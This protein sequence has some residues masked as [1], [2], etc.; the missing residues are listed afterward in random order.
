MRKAILFT[1][2]AAAAGCVINASQAAAP[3]EPTFTLSSASFQDGG[4]VPMRMAYIKDKKKPELL[5][6]EYLAAAFLGQ[7]AA[8]GEELCDHHV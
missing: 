4:L 8:G 1:A 3:P 5:R 6:P 7:S 2:V